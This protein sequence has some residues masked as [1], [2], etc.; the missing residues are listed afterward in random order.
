MSYYALLAKNFI[1]VDRCFW[2]LNAPLAMAD[3]Y[4]FRVAQDLRLDSRAALRIAHELRKAIERQ[5]Q[6]AR[7]DGIH[8]ESLP[9]PGN[10]LKEQNKYPAILVGEAAMAYIKMRK[11]KEEKLG[12]PA[13][14]K[15]AARKEAAEGNVVRPSNDDVEIKGGAAT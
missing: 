11:E 15:E 6:A 4:A 2:N 7:G 5:K 13:N 14:D 10:V 1:I 8:F 12:T 3:V 9:E